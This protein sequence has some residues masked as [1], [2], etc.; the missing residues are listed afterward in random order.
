MVI[1][2]FLTLSRP[3]CQAEAIRFILQVLSVVCNAMPFGRAILTSY[4]YIISKNC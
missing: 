1:F 3:I 2:H 4:I